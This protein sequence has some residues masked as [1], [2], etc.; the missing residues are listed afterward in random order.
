MYQTAGLRSTVPLNF[1]LQAL[2]RELF[3]PCLLFP[4]SDRTNHPQVSLPI[5]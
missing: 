3:P 4:S 2:I 1:D 5:S